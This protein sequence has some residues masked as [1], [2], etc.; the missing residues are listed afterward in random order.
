M[1][2]FLIK[3]GFAI[4]LFSTLIV[5]MYIVL[6]GES[7]KCNTIKTDVRVFVWGDSQMYQGLDVELLG[8]ELGKTVLTSARH[9][10]GVYDFLVS[11]KNI[12]IHAICVVAF[13]EAALLRKPLSDNNRTGFELSCLQLLFR[14][15]C[16]LDE[17]LRIANLNSSNIYY[18]VFGHGHG[19]YPYSDIIVQGPLAS[20]CGMFNEEKE[21]FAWKTKVYTDGIQRLYEKQA[22]IILVQFPFEQ[23]VENCARNSIN[24]HL[25]DSLKFELI[26]KYSMKYDTIVLH[27]D[28]LLLHDLSHLNEVGARL[29]T[30][31]MAEIMRTDTV[32]NR[33]IK[34]EIE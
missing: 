6:H 9:G 1:K 4:L 11:E 8:D 15:G 10:S 22:Q 26:E 16:P 12:P 13:A 19:L 21:Y 5:G 25:T 3:I 2:K 7:K 28:S 31:R 20:F 24:R 17:C 32:Y 33:F 34:V 29:V 23:Q 27:S 14:A 18:K 30:K